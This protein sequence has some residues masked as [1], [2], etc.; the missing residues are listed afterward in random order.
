MLLSCCCN[1][2]AQ[3]ANVVPI[4]PTSSG[5]TGLEYIVAENGA[6]RTRNYFPTLN[7]DRGNLIYRTGDLELLARCT[8]R[9]ISDFYNSLIENN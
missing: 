5:I 2:V 9:I 8:R 4:I 6:Q 3:R 1:I 7:L